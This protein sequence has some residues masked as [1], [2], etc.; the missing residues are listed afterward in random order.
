MSITHAKS[1]SDRQPQSRNW[2]ADT[3][4][5]AGILVFGYFAVTIEAARQQGLSHTE[6]AATPLELLH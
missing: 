5:V 1:H 6:Q 4:I 2:I 3:L